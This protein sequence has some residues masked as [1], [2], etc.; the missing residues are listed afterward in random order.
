V[1]PV[2]A[3][4]DGMREEFRA[5]LAAI[6]RNLVTM[7]GAVQAAMSRATSALLDANETDAEEVIAADAEIDAYYRIIEDKVY[8]VLARQAPVAGDLRL[9]ITSLHAAADLERMG[10][11][12]E[13]VARIAQRRLP[14]CAVA[15]PL[16]AQFKE[17][18]VVAER[19]AGKITKALRTHD[20]V[21]AAQLD[22][23]DDAMD[24]LHEA[25]FTTMFGPDWSDGVAAAVDAALL[26]RY[27]ERYADHAVNVGRHVVFLVTGESMDSDG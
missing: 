2:G 21:A 6:N 4:G 13:H 12:A 15:A 1:R 5:D 27:Y 22:R 23:D 20:V 25:L 19:I 18:G 9:V 11:L 7:S 17:M 8:D 3:Y 16:T 26:G 14:S 24:E 10:A